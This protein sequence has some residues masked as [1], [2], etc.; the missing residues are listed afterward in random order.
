MM[1]RRIFLFSFSMLLIAAF[2]FTPTRGQANPFEYPVLYS[3]FSSKHYSVDTAHKGR[4]KGKM[5]EVVQNGIVLW[6]AQPQPNHPTVM[7]LHG[8]VGGISK[9]GWKYRWLIE[10]GFGVVAMGYP[11]SSGSKGRASSRSILAAAHQTYKSL[12]RL[13]GNSPV[14]VMGESLGTGVAI[15]LSYELAQKGTPPAGIALHAPYSSIYAL[16]R[17]QAPQIAGLFKGAADPWP[18]DRYIRK[19][20]VPLFIMH[21]ARDKLVPV[22]QGKRLYDLSPS[23]NK[24]LATRKNAKHGN[25]W[26]KKSVQSALVKWMRALGTP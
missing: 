10:Q 5:R 24:Q 19:L 14:V 16:L 23:A 4:L 25:I 1:N 11:G 22:S 2:T 26:S 13:V 15:R 20:N 12:P 8:S 6:V 21:G 17:H 7:F 18:S 9:R 3:Q